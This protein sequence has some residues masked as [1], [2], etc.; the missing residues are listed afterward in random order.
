MVIRY[1]IIFSATL[2]T[3]A[4]TL[5]IVLVIISPGKPKVLTDNNDNYLKKGIS[6]K[7]YVQIG[8]IKQGM[9]VR[10]KNIENPVWLFV[11]G[12]PCFSEYFL[13][14][15]YPTGLEDFFTVCYW[16]QRGCGISYTHGLS[17][18]SIN[19]EQ[20]SN[21]LLD[22]TNYL[23]RRFKKEKIYILA[24]SGG[25]S[26]AIRSVADNPEL[27]HAYI[28]V[29]QITSQSE[30]EKLSY[31]YMVGEYASREESAKLKEFKKYPILDDD[32]YLPS[33]FSSLLRDESMHELGIGTMRRMKSVISGVFL[34]VWSCRAYTLKEK[35]NI[36]K[37]KLKFINKSKIKE[38]I[39]A[40]D[41]T[42][43]IS[44][45]DIPVYFFSGRYDMTV[46]KE[47]SSSFLQGIEAPVKGFYT[48]D[49]SAH[50]PM[51]EE[52]ERFL[53]IMIRDVLNK[54]A[55]LADK[56]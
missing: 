4:A 35:F 32:K 47:L 6:E 19:L 30:S 26:F 20:L 9:F 42:S 50:S 8:G 22:V 51:F 16:E 37:S 13:V 52:P 48:F 10:S 31:Q 38:Q 45:I 21:D 49:K 25:T 27:Y 46:N 41:L 15:R 7:T 18:E 44:R 54:R 36:W 11:H 29:A 39:L 23:R 1:I 56:Q 24:H 14:E 43:E 17:L 53:K 12:G 55:D 34:P 28:G 33:Y 3:L 2:L 40:L 5:F